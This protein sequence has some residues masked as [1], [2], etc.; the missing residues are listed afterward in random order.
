VAFNLPRPP[1]PS[2]V[3][4]SLSRGETM[5]LAVNGEWQVEPEA[6]DEET[7]ARFDQQ[8]EQRLEQL[9]A[10][11]DLTGRAN[12]AFAAAAGLDVSKIP[13]ELVREL[14][15]AAERVSKAEPPPLPE[16]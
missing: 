7:Q 6:V 8:T 9:R 3:L 2:E 15:Q 1:L 10:E 14:E 5:T 11:L 12:A 13:P 4:R 16:D